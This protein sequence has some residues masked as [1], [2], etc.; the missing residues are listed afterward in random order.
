MIKLHKPKFWNKKIGL[1][2]LLLYPLSLIFSFFFFFKKKFT[3]TKHFNIPIICV[4]NIYLGGTG[5]TPLSIFL[6]NQLT[7]LGK[8]PIILRK[9][10]VDHVDE[11]ALI[12]E[13]FKDLMTANNRVEALEQLDNSNFDVVILDDGFQDYKIKKN[14]N[15]ICFNQKQLIGNGLVLPAG[16][17]RENLSSLKNANIVLINGNQDKSFEKKIKNINSKIEIFYSSYHP[18]NLE[19]FRN[20]KLLAF[21]GIGNPENFFQMIEEN[22]LN[23]EKKIIFPDHYK[24]SKHE[25]Q[26]LISE[27]EQKNYQLI[28]T[29]K[30]YYKIKSY[31]LDKIKCFKI[32]LKIHNSQNFLNRIHQLYDQKI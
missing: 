3:K 27:A 31:S 19:E 22:N 32:E 8:K 2:A 4:G 26:K 24:F 21:A 29:E 7:K 13:N 15:I 20:K 12:K 9:Y 1:T 23:I 28:M 14:L 18:T 11:Y 30:D 10:Y 25:V 16:P 6:A 5:K 17:L